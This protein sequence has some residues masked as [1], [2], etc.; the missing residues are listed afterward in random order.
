MFGFPCSM[1]GNDAF[2][3]PKIE[4]RTSNIEN[5][6]QAI[7]YERIPTSIYADSDAASR[8]IAH[9]IAAIIRKRASE[10][11]PA[12]LGLA[13]GSSPKKV[14]SELIRMHREEGLSF[15]NVVTY[16]LDEYYPMESDAVQSYVRFMREQLFDHV[17]IP[18]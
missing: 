16:N 6:E 9:E 7:S 10:E 1:L 18:A 13:T 2:Q 8:A 14:Y 17:D 11:K 4:H 12:V 15:Q 5:M 3:I